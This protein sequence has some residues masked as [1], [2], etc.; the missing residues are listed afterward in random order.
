MATKGQTAS[1]TMTTKGQTTTVV[2]NGQSASKHNSTKAQ[3]VISKYT[4]GRTTSTPVPTNGNT[5]SAPMATTP[6]VKVTKGQTSVSV[7]MNKLTTYSQSKKAKT[8]I[9]SSDNPVTTTPPILTTN[10]L[11]NFQ[12]DKSQAFNFVSIGIPI[13]VILVVVFVIILGFLLRKRFYSENGDRYGLL[14]KYH[15][16]MWK[17]YEGFDRDPLGPA[18]PVF[19]HK[20]ITD[21]KTSSNV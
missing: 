11:T 2:T 20:I 19:M 8:S 10:N 13:I 9:L 5:M 14:Q 3:T 12:N 1:V 21:K 6:I 15:K 17:Y 18:K 16:N 4:T 7:S